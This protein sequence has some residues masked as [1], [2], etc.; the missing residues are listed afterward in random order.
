ML[1]PVRL[2]LLW[3]LAQ[4]GTMT[5]VGQACGYTSSAVSQHL[6]ALE[7][8]AG[9]RLYERAGRRV[10]L[11]AEG[12]RLAG[13]ARAVLDALE[14]AEADLRAAV[15][16]RGPLPVASFATAIAARVLPAIAAARSAYPDLRVV[17]REL[18]PA[19]AVEALRGGR[20]EVAITYTY[21]LIR[22][23]PPPGLH[24]ETLGAEPVLLA[25]RADHPAT[26]LDMLRD[27]E[28]IAGSRLR[29]DHELAERACGIA[30]F[31]PRITHAA[32]DYGLVLRMV[33]QGIGCA[34]VPESA[35]VVYG[36]PAGVRLLPVAT[37][38]LARHTHA[39]TRPATAAAPAV[40]AM[41]DLLRAQALIV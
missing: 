11:T 7:R 41:V 40:Q 14:G 31:L 12:L 25:L 29:A 19:E 34:L 13:H 26:E 6:A 9:T 33:E 18:E 39:V 30:G 1:D 27:E 17:V 37:V 28:W 16:P 8:E 21:S 15:T 38:P 4:R 5:A 3:E 24:V 36:V 20:C 22:Q 35:A 10:R 2:R 23:P 32:D